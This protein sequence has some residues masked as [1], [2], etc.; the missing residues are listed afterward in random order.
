MHLRARAKFLVLALA[1]CSCLIPQKVGAF[2]SAD[3]KG[4]NVHEQ[5]TLEALQG[6]LSD[7]NL[8]L[9]CRACT[10]QDRAGSEGEAEERRH[11]KGDSV[12]AAIAYIERERKKVLNYAQ[13]A[14]TSPEDRARAL[15]HFGL[16]LHTVQDFYSRTNYVEIKLEPL[17]K[18]GASADPYNVDL[19]DW[20]RLE[21]SSS[22]QVDGV[23]LVN[24]GVDKDNGQAL[25]G[26]H[27]FGSTNYFKV[28]RGLAIRETQR[29]WNLL[30]NLIRNKCQAR[31][32]V[33]VAALKQASCPQDVIAELFQ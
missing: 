31:A 21:N 27:S 4:G 24:H 23:T 2:S 32:A 12:S 11:F 9:V 29:Q 33:V 13:D 5:I 19:P 25:S 6:T 20:S 15:Y 7:N 3:D 26:K 30:E 1:A 17:K 16:L 28:A 10:S 8:A 22:V 14:D 18:A